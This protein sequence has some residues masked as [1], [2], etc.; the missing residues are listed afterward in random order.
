VYGA[1]PPSAAK[2]ATAMIDYWVSF[3]NSLD[4]N[5]NHGSKRTVFL[6]PIQVALSTC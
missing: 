1:Q 3:A 6:F 4:P 5:D 2:L